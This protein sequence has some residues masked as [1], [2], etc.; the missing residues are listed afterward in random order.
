MNVLHI[1]RTM[2]QGGAEKIVCQLAESMH[3]RGDTV[4]VASSGGG[5]VERLKADGIIHYQIQDLEYKSPCVMLRTLFQLH[6]IIVRQKI[7]IVHT[8]HRMAAVYAYILRVFHP[9]LKH[10]Y[11]AHNVF[12]DKKS[13]TKAALRDAAVVAVGSGVK[14]NLTEF[15]HISPAQITVIYN[16]VRPEPSENRYR[17]RTLDAWK[18]QG[19]SLLGI[20][21]R[22]SVQKG[23]DIFLSVIS[24][25][26]RKGRHIRGI[27]VGDGELKKDLIQM[28]YDLGIEGDI[29]FL[30]YQEHISTLISQLDLI[31]MPSRWEGFPLLPLE[32]FAEKKTIVGSNISGINEIVSDGENGRLVMKDDTRLFTEAAAELLDNPGLRKRL[33]ENGFD[34]YRQTFSYGRFTEQYYSLYQKVLEEREKCGY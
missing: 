33:G 23:V 28:A 9:K 29:L 26:K 10:I 25:L 20:I 30:G 13:L 12:Y 4:C 3:K 18:E 14:K 27:V 21:G 31:I 24:D 11:T 32:V 19:V 16:A 5:Y 15:F 34:F 7:D 6:R 22:L 1:S 8:H 17:N 2:G